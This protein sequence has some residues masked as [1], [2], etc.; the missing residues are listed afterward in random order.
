MHVSRPGLVVALAA[1]VLVIPAASADWASFHADALNTGYLPGVA[2][3]V[4]QDVW[5]SNSTVGGAQVSASPVEKDNILVIADLKGLVRGLDAESGHEFWRFLMPAPV[6]GTPA[7]AGERVY[8]VDSAGNLKALNLKTGLEEKPQVI[9]AA[10]G[11]TQSDVR[12]SEGKLF[13]GTENG[14]MRAFLASTL[15]PLW[16]FDVTKYTTTKTVTGTSPNLTTTCT[17]PMSGQPIRGAPS[18]FNGMVFFGSFN[19]YVYAVN[20]NG[21]GDQTT[22]LIWW[23]KTGDVVVG[24]PALDIIDASTNRVVVGSYDGKVYAYSP[25][26]NSGAG[27]CSATNPV[28]YAGSTVTPAWSYSVPSVVDSVTGETQISKVHSSPAV[29][30]TKV[31]VGANNGHVYSLDARTGAYLWNQ[32]AGDS[33]RGVSS[34]PAVAGGHVV[35]GSQNKNVYWLAA[36][37][38]AIEKSF[39]T[40]SAIETSPALD[41]DK[42]FVAAKDGTLYMFGPK[43]PPRPDLVV[44]AVAPTLSS[45]S[46]T[47][48]NQGTASAP[49]SK[50]RILVDDIFLAD[51]NVTALGPGNSTTVTAIGAITPALHRF[52][53]KADFGTPDAVKESNESNNDKTDSLTLSPP[54]PPVAPPAAATKKKS[55]GAG[56]ALLSVLVVGAA[57]GRRRYW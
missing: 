41:G 45:V 7:I 23:H 54:A 15:T 19:H 6:A 22:N 51:V 11:A 27:K 35:V 26:G 43:V 32:T 38:G 8:V 31:Y 5:W 28:L 13:I 33:I 9:P 17:D 12:E 21:N 3:P 34:S 50:V 57:L 2:Y 44:T 56:V 20:E 16:T 24:A 29:A 55:P 53:A 48:A 42:A 14:Q 10:L 30:G 1:L 52:T 39:S 46:V 36:D 18:I 49:A 37:T 40:Q 25:N 4:Y 47:V